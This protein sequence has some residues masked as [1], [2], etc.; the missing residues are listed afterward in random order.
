MSSFLYNVSGVNPKGEMIYATT[1]DSF[2]FFYGPKSKVFSVGAF[3]KM[4]KFLY[5]L[6]D[7]EV[8][9]LLKMPLNDCRTAL[10]SKTRVA[11]KN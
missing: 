8:T 10:A 4:V 7:K 3:S 6:D 1:L 9:E 11:G 5:V 2:I